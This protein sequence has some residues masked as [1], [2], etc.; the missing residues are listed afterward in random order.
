MN[1]VAREWQDNDVPARINVGASSWW[2]A[3]CKCATLSLVTNQTFLSTFLWSLDRTV[4]VSWN[5]KIPGRILLGGKFY[6]PYALAEGNWCIQIIEKMLELSSAVLP[7]P[8][9]SFFY[10]RDLTVLNSYMNMSSSDV[11]L[12]TVVNSLQCKSR[13]ILS[14]A[15]YWRSITHS[16]ILFR[17]VFL[18]AMVTRLSFR[19]PGN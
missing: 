6:C 14:D 2:A 16:F 11:R 12:C 9:P 1:L 5:P 15:A 10:Q 19:L 3:W 8:S 17:V 7:M 18:W 4:C 13:Q